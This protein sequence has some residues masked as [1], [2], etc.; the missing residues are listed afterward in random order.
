MMRIHVLGSAAGGG[1]PQWN[2]NCSNCGGLRQG[3]IKARARTQ[4]SIAV[5]GDGISW[6]LFN[7]SPDIRTQ[8]EAFPAMQP[9]RSLRDTGIIGI[10]LIDSQID[11]TTGLLVLRE[12]QPLNIYC[13]DMVHQDLTTGHPLFNV[14]GHYCG[15]NWHAVP[16]EPGSHFTVDGVEDLRFTAV[17]LS[18][19][20]PPYSPHRHDPHLG[21]NISIR[22]EDLKS[23]KSL[24]YA[25][26]LGK[27]EP[28]IL[29]YMEQADCLMVDGTF[30]RDD[31]MVVAGLGQKLASDMG[32]LPQSGDDGMLSVLS[33]MQRPRKILIHIN[34]S[35]PILDEKS[36]ERAIVDRAGVEVAYD[37]MDITL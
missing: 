22:V 30:W 37:G 8:L 19:K 9:A 18:S 16:L 24:Y 33:P 1:F 6:V 31:E 25:P 26:G 7:A 14:L 20:A 21:D 5:S 23:G 17:P 27:I 34:N 35:N 13:S 2:C 12:G 4:S 10:V 11:H 29:P 28:H 36:P 32:H 3:R 15:V